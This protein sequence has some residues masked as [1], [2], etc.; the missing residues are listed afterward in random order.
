MFPLESIGFATT[1]LQIEEGCQIGNLLLDSGQS[2]H[3]VKLSKT[4]SIIDGLRCF[5]RYVIDH[6]SHEFVIGKRRN[7]NLL[8]TLSLL[9][10]DLIEELTHGAPVG[11]VFL[12]RIVELGDHL[13]CQLLG[14]SSKLVF[15]LTGKYFHDLEQLVGCVV[16]DIKEVAETAT[17]SDIDAEQVLHLRTISC[18]Y[19]NELTAIILHAFHELL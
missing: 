7:I 14:I 15:L 11:K 13:E 1:N 19:D 6:N 10:A 18:S 3:T 16:V 8:Q 9:S 17:E 5:V 4:I 2:N 12:T